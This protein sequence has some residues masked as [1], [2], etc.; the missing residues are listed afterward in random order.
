M[1]HTSTHQ[2]R[3]AICT[4]FVSPYRTPVFRRL[5]ETTGW[6]VRLITNTPMEHDRH[7]DAVD[8]SDE[9][10]EVSQ[11]A[12]FTRS[13]R[14]G[15]GIS[16]VRHFPAGLPLELVRFKPHAI[17]TGELGPR[18]ALAHAAGAAIGAAVIPWTYDA[19]PAPRALGIAQLRA[20]MAR[21]SPA[22]VGMGRHARRTL[23]TMGV[24][25][26]QIYDAHNAAN[27]DGIKARLRH[28]SHCSAVRQI[29]ERFA[30]RRIAVVAGRMIKA[31]SVQ[32]IVDA[33]Q[34]IPHSARAGWVLVFV[35][36]GPERA[37]AERL[38]ATGIHAV[39]AVPPSHIPDWMAAADLH[40]FGSVADP[41]GLVVNEAM[42]CGT[43]T[44]CSVRAGC[45]DDLISDGQTGFVFDPA[46]GAAH[47]ADAMWNAMT[48]PSLTAIGSRA[49]AHAAQFT[50]TR[51][52]QGMAEAVASALRS[53]HA[54]QEA[55]S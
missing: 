49:R 28:A 25:P 16:S 34:Y 51:M 5:A 44:L 31:K 29:R 19:H 40:V 54:G 7:W 21:C 2:T 1:P 14:N 32:L 6:R 48:T 24:A 18:T 37:A 22:V 20:A 41:W 10:F 11:C 50:P 23:E 17:I 42:H 35:G 12:S 9:P 26:D 13:R 47:T 45:C 30:G 43:P 36:D 27:I 52:A 46:R 15:N 55:R 53:D 39:G 3:V 4:N 38:E 33:W 8:A